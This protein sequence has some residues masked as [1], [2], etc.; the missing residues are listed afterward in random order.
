VWRELILGLT[1]EV[2]FAAPV[3]DRA[4]STAA[5]SLGGDLPEPLAALLRETDGV[6]GP[7]GVGLVWSLERVVADNLAFRSNADFS[8]LYMPFDPLLFFAIKL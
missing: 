1:T 6:E 8:E 7:Y 5:S 3:S 2:S 4:L